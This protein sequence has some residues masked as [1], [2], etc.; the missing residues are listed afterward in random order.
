V[1]LRRVA[2]VGGLEFG[3]D[4]GAARLKDSEEFTHG[5][6]SVGLRQVVEHQ[7]GHHG[8]ERRVGE[9]Q[10]L[11]GGDLELG[12]CLPAGGLGL[13]DGDHLGGGIHPVDRPVGPDSPGQ[14]ERESAGAA[15]DV[16]DPVP[17]QQAQGVPDLGAEPATAAGEPGRDEQVIPA[18]PP[19]QRAVLPT[20]RACRGRG[21]VAAAHR[22]FPFR[23][24]QGLAGQPPLRPVP[25]GRRRD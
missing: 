19:D 16:K 23:R 6:Q 22:G 21:V 2:P 1:S 9:R 15:A 11:R 12:G 10:G 25:G 17:G 20:V 7:A 18:G 8:V 4:Q 5:G 14:G 13:R 3:D 24:A